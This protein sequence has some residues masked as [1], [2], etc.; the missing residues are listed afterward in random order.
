[1]TPEGRCPKCG[2]RRHGWSLRNP[3][4]QNCPECGTRLEIKEADKY[5]LDE[6]QNA[7]DPGYRDDES[8]LSDE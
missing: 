3:Q 4:Y 7:V 5:F 6:A 2:L 8:D 1:M